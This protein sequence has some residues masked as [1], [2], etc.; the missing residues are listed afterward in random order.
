MAT[1]TAAN[2]KIY[3]EEFYGGVFESLQQNVQIFNEASRGAL[4]LTSEMLKGDYEKESFLTALAGVIARRDTTSTADATAILMAMEELISV[5]LNRRVGPIEQ[6]LDAWRKVASDQQE[7][8][9]VIGQ[10]VGQHKATD[11]ANTLVAA[12]NAALSGQAAVNHTV[13]G[14]MNHLALVQGLAKFGDRA[15]KII[16]WV[17]H[18]K[19]YFDLVGQSITDKIVNVAD[20]AI[21]EGT[22]A[23][24]GRPVIV[25]DSASLIDTAPT[26]DTYATLGLVAGAGIAK[27]SESQDIIGEVVTGK[28][29]LIF[30]IQGEHAFNVGLKGFKW[31]VTNG[32]ANPLDAAVATASNW[33][34]V[35]TD[36]KDLPGVRIVTQ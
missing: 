24:L 27:E 28:N 9:F 33:D 21:Y 34:K 32:G 25:T 35:A 4:V 16:A 23:T 14:T 6:T 26:P 3:H 36:N 13:A 8:S 11:Y 7:M 30:R 20:V 17:M 5:K 29:N 31:D 22:P 2:F 19:P 10:M 1:G 18:S 12:I 15:S